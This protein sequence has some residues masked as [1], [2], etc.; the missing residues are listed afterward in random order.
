M[1]CIF[2]EIGTSKKV[3]NT[4]LYENDYF[5]I[6]PAKG[7]IVQGHVLI[8]SKTHNTSLMSV[9]TLTKKSFIEI[10]T[11]VIGRVPTYNN[12]LFFE[13]GSYNDEKG[14]KTIEHMHIHVLPNFNKYKNILEHSYKIEKKLK[15]IEI[16]NTSLY[17]AYLLMG[18]KKGVFIYNGI[19]VESQIIRTKIATLNKKLIPYWQDYDNMPA[20]LETLKMWKN[21]K[22]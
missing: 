17:F 8:V 10:I 21:V 7:P 5:R 18:D 20:L 15:I 2:C 12:Y 6:I 19:S 13:H 11:K 16:P 4:T 9:D 1:N 3:E 22:F 14:G